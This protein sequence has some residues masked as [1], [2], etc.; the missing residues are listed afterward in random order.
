MAARSTSRARSSARPS[1]RSKVVSARFSSCCPCNELCRTYRG[2]RHPRSDRR[3]R[4]PDGISE[5]F[6][7]EG[8]AHHESKKSFSRSRAVPCAQRDAFRRTEG[9]KGLREST[10]ATRHERLR[11]RPASRRNQ[12][13]DR[14]ALRELHSRA[15]GKER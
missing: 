12:R 10:R 6:S 4:P 9:E 2:R 14:P 13:R 11:R 5:T 8:V 1:S 7:Q 15:N 3:R